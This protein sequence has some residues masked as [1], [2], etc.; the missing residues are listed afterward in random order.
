[1]PDEVKI[2]LPTDPDF[3]ELLESRRLVSG[4]DIQALWHAWNAGEIQ[5]TLTA[6]NSCSRRAVLTLAKLNSKPSRGASSSIS[7]TTVC[8]PMSIL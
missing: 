5:T 7:P 2:V 3:K 6:T 1:M 4:A 8:R